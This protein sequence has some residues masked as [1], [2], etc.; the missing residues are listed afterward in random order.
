[1]ESAGKSSVMEMIA[2]QPFFPRSEGICTRLPFRLQF[3]RSPQLSGISVS[4]QNIEALE[5]RKFGSPLEVQQQIIAITKQLKTA[6][7]RIILQSRKAASLVLCQL[8]GLSSQLRQELEKKA[9]DIALT[10]HRHFLEEMPELQ[11]RRAAL[12]RKLSVLLKVQE[13]LEEWGEI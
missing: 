11:N 1:M 2:G 5:G 10:S 7:E 3:R 13:D 12:R 8:Q 4:F 9:L 6:Q